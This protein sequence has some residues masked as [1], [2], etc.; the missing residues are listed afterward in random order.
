MKVFL[1]GTNRGEGELIKYYQ[2]I[3]EEIRKLGYSHLSDFVVTPTND[4]QE[5]MKEGRE[6][7][8][9]FYNEMINDIQLAD[10][11]IFEASTP[12]LAVGFLIQ[13][14]LEYSKP[15]VVLYY[16]DN[17]VYFLSGIEDEKLIKVSYDEKNY[18][19]VIK[20]ALDHAREK[21]DKRFNFFLS[22][23]LLTYLED[24]SNDQG[25]TK[26]KILRDLI[27]EHMRKRANPTT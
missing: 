21:R 6:K 16:K 17:L 12:S 8:I 10:I 24:V 20:K 1:V 22:P 7:H 19:Q 26:S 2:L 18:K 23:K 4:F 27:V 11:C 3:Y 13:R 25:V 15:T 5:K 9:Q 14:S